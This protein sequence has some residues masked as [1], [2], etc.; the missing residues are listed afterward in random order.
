M[1]KHHRSYMK[2]DF[3]QISTGVL[4]LQNFYFHKMK[5]SWGNSMK[6]I[7]HDAIF[8]IINF[9]I[10]DWLSTFSAIIIR[11]LIICTSK[12]YLMRVKIK[13]NDK[14]M[15]NTVQSKSMAAIE[16]KGGLFC[17]CKNEG[18][19]LVLQVNDYTYLSSTQ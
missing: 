19:R 10:L 2:Y 8:V 17:V 14:G 3:K 5:N 13:T 6:S 15:K 9:M 1:N 12:Y 11:N 7:L 4:E 16:K 18:K